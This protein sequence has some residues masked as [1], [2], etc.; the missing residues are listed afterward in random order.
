MI[1]K[2]LIE[3]MPNPIEARLAEKLARVDI[4]TIGHFRHRGF[5]HRSVA[6][7]GPRTGTLVGTAVTLAIPGPDSTL[8]HH[9]VGLLRPG[10]ILVIDRLGDD[11]HACLGGGVARAIRRTGAAGVVLDGPCTDPSEILEVGLPLWCR[12]VS[13]ITTRLLDLGG[14][15]NHPVACGNVPV[16]AG[17]AVL[18]DETGV[19]ILPAAEADGAAD[20]ALA[21][22]ERSAGRQERM[23]SGEKLGEVS[24]ASRMV[25]DSA[26]RQKGA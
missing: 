14:A 6:A 20:E 3:A 16:L 10:D 5:V 2:Y 23:S 26:G 12:G 19:L 13:G 22:Q 11:R 17:Y 8:L 4:A 7:V 25:R 21:R 24:G 1:P 18:A 9:A 15:L